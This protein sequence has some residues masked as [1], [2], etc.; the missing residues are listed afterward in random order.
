MQPT[1]DALLRIT[2]VTCCIV[3]LL[4]LVALSVCAKCYSRCTVCG[5]TIKRLA[6]CFTVLSML[7]ELVVALHFVR[8]FDPEVK[9]LCELL[10][11]LIQYTSSV[12]LLL[13]LSICLVLFFEV[14]KVTTSWKLEFYKKVKW[15][16]FTCCDRKINKLEVT[17]F[18]FSICP[19][20]SL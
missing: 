4:V 9:H 15:S 10:G 20:S 11:F 7:Y 5:T 1:T 3:C 19:S 2:G 6:F 14:L 17:I 8:Y 12:A 13:A 16:T 18:N